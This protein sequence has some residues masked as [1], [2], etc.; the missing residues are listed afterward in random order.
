[1]SVV[2]ERFRQALTDRRLPV[3]GAG[4]PESTITGLGR[5]LAPLRVPPD[6]R[7]L[8]LRVPV[9]ALALGLKRGL[10]DRPFPTAFED[11]A[12]CWWAWTSMRDRP[13]SMPEALLLVAR[14]GLR[15]RFVE[16]DAA[17]REGGRVF[18][19]RFGAES[20]ELRY[21]SVRDWVEVLTEAIADESTRR[22]GPGETPMWIEVDRECELRLADARLSGDAV[23][24]DRDAREWPEWWRRASRE[25]DDRRPVRA[26]EMSVSQLLWS[27][28][29]SATVAGVVSPMLPA[30]SPAR[31]DLVDGTAVLDVFFPAGFPGFWLLSR[32]QLVELEVTTDVS[33]WALPE[34]ADRWE[35]RFPPA[36]VATGLRLRMYG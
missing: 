36:A 26:P 23:T 7:E 10:H 6:L 22:L 13:G 15:H 25:F 9:G 8:W 34:G 29:P 27:Q 2:V 12:F 19:W 30:E 32:V 5:E 28:P 1:M 14:D 17:G 4:Y 3:P 24:V 16:L 31:V 18:D 35:R 21:R 20:L 11:P 33:A